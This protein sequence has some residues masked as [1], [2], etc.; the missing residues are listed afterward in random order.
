MRQTATILA[1]FWVV[2]ANAQPTELF[3]RANELYQQ[4]NFAEAQSLYDSIVTMGYQHAE[5]YYNLGNTHYR[6]GH[7]GLAIL[8]YEKALA[9]DPGDEDA[10]HN[11]TLAKQQ[12]VD[13]FNVVP[14]P[15]LKRLFNDVATVFPSSIWT[16]LALVLLAMAVVM[17]L[18]FLFRKRSSWVISLFVV[19]LILAISF[20]G[21]AYGTYV[22]EQE[23]FAVVI[24]PNTYVKSAPATSA[25]DLFIL[26]EGTKV[27][28]LEVF[29]GWQKVRLPDGKLGWVVVADL[30][31]I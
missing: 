6:Q 24:T 7:I 27:K 14:T 10:Q 18:L 29:E 2:L 15:P 20:E 19:G 8:N 4:Q 21:F 9:L 17:G 16:I 3:S 25:A 26:H 30:E 13:E 23:Q 5:T 11:L 31:T 28:V 22:L 12:T 1:L